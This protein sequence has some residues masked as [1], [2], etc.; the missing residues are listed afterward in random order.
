M[1]RKIRGLIEVLLI[2]AFFLIF[3]YLIQKNLEFIKGFIG[4]SIIGVIIYILI[5]IIS[6]VVAPITTLPLITLASNLW[7]VIPAGII[8]VFAWT[9]GAWIAFWIGRKY[10]AQIVKKFISLEDVHKIEKKIPKEHLFWTVVL[11]R[12]ISP[13]DIL[14]YAIGIFTKM[15]TRDYLLATIIGIT[16][17]AFIF[18]YL[19]S[20]SVEYQ[21]MLFLIFG[22]LILIGWIARLLYKK[23]F[24]A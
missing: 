4:H 1:N 16:P 17:L 9:T 19:G 8:S 2:V 7:G 24:K 22:V 14:S 20:V 12:L 6:I 3:S 23:Y 5:E 11:L 15:K 13:M 10:G 21:I 18:A